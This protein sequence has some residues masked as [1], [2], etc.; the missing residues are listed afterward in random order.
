LGIESPYNTYLHRGLP[1]G[2]ICCPG[3]ASILGALRPLATRD[4]Y[5]VARPD[6]Y[7]IFSQ[8]LAEHDRAIQKVK[9]MRADEGG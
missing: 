2:P 9:Q 7:H 8:T 4:L 5:Y 6:G 3:L 1:P